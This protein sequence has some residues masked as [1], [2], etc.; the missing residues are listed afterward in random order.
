MKK[1]CIQMK[2]K[3]M[4]S[5]KVYISSILS[6]IQLVLDE[7]LIK[8]GK[9]SEKLGDLTTNDFLAYKK[10]KS[11]F[12]NNLDKKNQMIETL[13]SLVVS[14]DLNKLKSIINPFLELLNDLPENKELDILSNKIF[15]LKNVKSINNNISKYN[16]ILEKEIYIDKKITL[17]AMNYSRIEIIRE[18]VF[19]I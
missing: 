8:S 16:E 5:A 17:S 15:T 18:K 13:K 2:L 4:I 6:E 9:M 10:N 14:E 1:G 12:D 11:V 19:S 7:S 3:Y